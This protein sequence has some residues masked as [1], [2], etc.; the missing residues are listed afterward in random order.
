FMLED[1]GAR[2]VV[3]HEELFERLPLDGRVTVD[4]RKAEPVR[5]VSETAGDR[6]EGVLPVS[7]ACLLYTSG[8]TGR[9]KGALIP[10]SAVIRLVCDTDYV[11]LSASSVMAQTSSASFDPLVFE[12]WGALLNGGCLVIVPPEVVTA[13]E[14]LRALLR[15]E[16]VT[17][18]FMVTALFH[19]T[20]SLVPDVFASVDQVYI[21]GEAINPEVVRRA[22]ATGDTRFHN[23]YGPTEVTTYSTCEPLR[24]GSM[25]A[26]R[27]GS[28]IRNTQAWVVDRFG[29]LAPVGVPGEVFLG[30]P[31]VA[32]GYRERPVLTAEKFV[33][34]A[35]SGTVGGRLY[36]TGDL[37]R[38]LPDGTL[39]FLGRADSQVKVRGFRIEPGEIETVLLTHPRVDVAA[40]TTTRGTDNALRLAGYAQGVNLSPADATELRAYLAERLPEYMV[41]LHVMILD[42]LPQLPNG[43]IDRKTLPQAGTSGQTGPIRAV[44]RRG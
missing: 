7:P 6:V 36:R 11:S 4:I 35:F 43:K 39:E 16:G 24:A 37:A 22:M 29:G 26:A 25:T 20:V 44:R 34:D 1:S 23:V 9:P 41:P 42:T 27:I 3:G 2:V 8:S 28:P 30:G 19:A 10:H 33:P 18:A 5:V 40:V 21:G 15:S 32:L 14:S 17:T 38:W 12:V 13:P 31:G